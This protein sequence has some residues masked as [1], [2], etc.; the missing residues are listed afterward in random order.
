MPLMPWPNASCRCWRNNFNPFK[1]M[2][3]K[4]KFPL[5]LA[6]WLAGMTAQAAPQAP[7]TV[8]VYDFTGEAESAGLGGKI[9]TLVTADL[10]A[11]TNLV[12]LERA[13]LSQI[14][15]EQAFGISGMVS[16]DAAAKIGQITGAKVLVAGQVLKT[17][18]DH[19]VIVATIIG[20]ETGRLFADQ[21]EG[22]TDNLL[23]LTSD[24]SGKIARTI[25]MQTTNLM[26]PV[27]ETHAERVERIVKSITG[28]NRPAVSINI[29][30]NNGLG[31]NWR[32]DVFESEL[33]IILLKAGFTVVDE[34]SDKKADVQIIGTSG[35]ETGLP[36]GGLLTGRATVDLKIQERRTGNI[37]GFDSQEA[38]A[39]DLGGTAAS[40]AAVIKAADELAERILPLLAQ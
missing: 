28:K 2:K 24:L 11:E 5:V 32:D 17:G 19:L 8:A 39:T 31:Q 25:S 30:A 1:T 20:T 10:T 16:A 40:K 22:T 4:T 37:I 27:S 23:Q 18:D 3:L 12:M 15:N 13:D 21:V 7:L 38:T 9:T 34:N 35:T 29:T 33:G 36:R 6:L 26:T 14:L